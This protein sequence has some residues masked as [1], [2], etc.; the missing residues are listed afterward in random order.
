MK[1]KKKLFPISSLQTYLHFSEIFAEVSGDKNNSFSEIVQHIF[2]FQVKT[3]DIDYIKLSLEIEQSCKFPDELV[4]YIKKMIAAYGYDVSAYLFK[5][6]FPHDKKSLCNIKDGLGCTALHKVMWHPNPIE[7]AKLLLHAA[8]DKKL[9]FLFVQDTENY[10]A[11][12]EAVRTNNAK[13]TKFL[14]EAAGNKALTLISIKNNNGYTAL[15]MKGLNHTP[16]MME[17][18]EEITLQFLPQQQ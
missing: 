13:L 8:N 17:L 14:L 5:Q 2:S 6:Y 3:S 7:I 18:L 16:E 9:E 15:G 12:H 4:Y 10:T 11:L 1:P